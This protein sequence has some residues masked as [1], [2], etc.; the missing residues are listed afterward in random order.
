[1]K[2]EATYTFDDFFLVPQ[3]S[4]IESRKDVNTSAQ[5]TRNYRIDVPLLAAP[6]DSV[7]DQHMMTKLAQVGA[8]GC[9]HRFMSIEEQADQIKRVDGWIKGQQRSLNSCR[10]DRDYTFFVPPLVASIG[11]T[12]DYLARAEAS[13]SA[14]ANVLLID[15]AHGD[16]KHVKTALAALNK[17]SY[18]ASFDVIAGNI[19]TAGAAM[20]LEDWGVDALRVGIG[21]GSMCET[22]VRTGIGVPQLSAVIAVASVATVPVISDGGIKL[23]GDV[24]KAL[25]AGADT[26]MLGSLFAGTFEAPGDIFETGQWPN[27]Q[28][29]K[30]FRGS[31]SA[32]AKYSA[33]GTADYVEGTATMV[34]I[35][36]SVE[37]VV[38]TIMDGLRSS[39]SYVG[40]ADLKEFSAK[41]EFVRITHAGLMEA[42]P[43]GLR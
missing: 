22:R 39:M 4:E 10:R 21:G 8:T 13:I 34:P 43:H 2:I 30:I 1:M 17:L 32:S 33:H 35:K 9:L 28:R 7:C 24:A 37:T 15:V 23:P 6:M 26:V 14:G 20:R 19:A 42:H 18:R 40:A 3:Y 5:L 41:A 38:S 29:M 16:H 25:A 31:A 12:G 27:I 36:G 11:A